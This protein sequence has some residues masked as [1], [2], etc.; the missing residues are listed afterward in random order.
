MLKALFK[1]QF[2]ELAA[3]FLM[4]RR[5]GK[6]RSRAA[7]AV[8]IAFFAVMLVGLAFTFFTL[9]K[10]I[11]LS[12]S[13]EMMFLYYFVMGLIAVA[14]GL[15]GSVFNAYAT[16]F[17]AKDNEFLL[18][19]PIPPRKIVFVRVTSL[20]LLSILYESVVLVPTFVARMMYRGVTLLGAI[21]SF[22]LFFVLTAL[23]VALSLALA[24]VVAAIARKVK[25]KSLV[26]V[27]LSVLLFALYYFAYFRAQNAIMRLSQM[28]VVPKAIKTWLFLFYH[29]GWAAEGKAASMAIF[30]GIS[31]GAFFLAY[32]A[33][34][35]FFIRFTTSKKSFSVQGKKGKIRVR[36]K[37]VAL[38]SR[39][40]KRFLS[41]PNYILNCAFG[42]LL[43]LAAGVF[44]FVKAKS[45]YALID[46]LRAVLPKSGGAIVAMPIVFLA[47]AMN[48]LTA[49]SVS[50][51]GN[52][53][54]IVRS[55]PVS[56]EEVFRAKILLHLVLTL[57]PA[58]FLAAAGCYAIRADALT[59]L[60][61]IFGTAAFVL[62]SA[63]FGLTL[64]LVKPS[65]D[66]TSENAALKQSPSVLISIF[67]EYFI[68]M[69]L[70]ALYLPFA[71]VLRDE[72]YLAI[73]LFLFAAADGALALWL[74]KVGTKKFESL[75]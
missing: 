18:S 33:L 21:N 53:L 45:L 6:A 41:S 37:G 47:A 23:V 15:F 46:S 10:G 8:F 11:L 20:S 54:W 27:V 71:K 24:F 69:A 66:W 43:M 40:I 50:L 5:K 67:G 70:A 65:L 75:G 68:V 72:T 58:L 14:I 49:P 28:T 73:L 29:M 4:D 57:F 2:R 3:L 31:F 56:S 44:L 63:L 62:F 39:E 13:D 9:A 7:A 60:I 26:S 51:E 38:F 19:L 55:L 74:K 52:K 12:V 22:L 34:S 17:E 42:T 59:A 64:N 35:R 16:V 1:K 61:S 32:F 25:R 36:K 48:D 30:S